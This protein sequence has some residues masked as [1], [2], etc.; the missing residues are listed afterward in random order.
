MP[1]FVSIF[2]ST[3]NT[4]IT[5]NLIAM[6][7]P[8]EK[9]EGIY[10][11]HID[12]VVRMLESKHKD[13]YKIYNLCSER[14]YDTQRFQRRVSSGPAFEFFFSRLAF[15]LISIP[16]FQVAVYPFNDHNPPKI[17]LIQ[18][19]CEDVHSW[20]NEHRENIAAVHCK[21]GKGR[22]GIRYSTVGSTKVFRT[23]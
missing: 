1:A 8:A 21:A 23:I 7:Y 11:N 18:R 5:D 4:D 10:R 12:D 20:L 19:F 17:E 3:P 13:H 15:E 16:N 9:L 22:T 14:S 6:G 2:S